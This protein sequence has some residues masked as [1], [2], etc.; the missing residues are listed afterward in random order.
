MSAEERLKWVAFHEI[1]HRGVANLA[2]SQAYLSELERAGKNP[3]VKNLAKKIY[4]ARQELDEKYHVSMEEAA[5]EAL[6]E[7]NA[8]LRTGNVKQI[9][10]QYGL[11]FP[12][13]IRPRAKSAA[14]R[15]IEA[16][17]RIINRM[18]GRGP[19]DAQIENLLRR[20]ND[21]GMTPDG[22]PGKAPTPTP[23]QPVPEGLDHRAGPHHQA[24]PQQGEV[25]QR[26]LTLW[27]KTLGTQLNAALKN[28]AFKK[29][30][31]LTQRL[32]QHVNNDAY[33]SLNAAPDVLSRLEDWNDYKRDIANTAKRPA[34]R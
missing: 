18:F 8:A 27:Q 22:G 17:K 26:D 6:A 15:F 34:R 9:K 32:I 11:H 5:E 23:L 33:D 10:E 28:P 1:T 21:A 14:A 4:E 20:T 19:T 7:I 13:S 24:R 2:E 25:A 3:Y 29:V 12:L 16:V 31:D 30:Y